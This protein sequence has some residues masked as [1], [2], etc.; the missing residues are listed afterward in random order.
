[1]ELIKVS[2]LTQ[3]TL[4]KVMPHKKKSWAA[5]FVIFTFL[6]ILVAG[7]GVFS[8]A[9]S[10]AYH[11]PEH[12]DQGHTGSTQIP[13][14]DTK[15]PGEVNRFSCSPV[16]PRTGN[17]FYVHQD[18]FIPGCGFSL[19]IARSYDSH[20]LY[21]GP[22]GH[23]WK[24]NSDVTLTE[25]SDE[26]G[27]YAAIRKSNGVRVVFSK[28]TDGSYNPPPGRHDTLR[29]NADDTFTWFESGCPTCGGPCYQFNASGCLTAILDANNNQ[30]SFSYD[31]T[32]KL[33]QVSDTSGR[34]LAITY[35]SN[36][37]ISAIQDPADRTFSYG[38]DSE[39]NLIQY[40]DPLGNTTTYTYDTNHRLTSIT[41]P[42]G[43]AMIAVTYDDKD[44][45]ITYSGYRGTWTYSYDPQ[46]NTTYK[47]DPEGNRWT[48]TYSDTGQLLTVKDPYNNTTTYD[49]DDNINLI[50]VKDARGFTTAFTYDDHGNM[51]TKTGPLGN[52]TTY[53]YDTNHNK[54]S[55]ITDPLGNTSKLE[56]DSS[57][58]I[59]K[60]IKD[61]GG[62]L[63]HETTF[64]YDSKGHVASFADPLNNTRTFTY[65]SYGN[66][67]QLT[68]AL[69]NTTTFTYDIA[70]N[71]LTETDPL[72]NTTTFSYD[73]LSRIIGKTDATG[74]T[75]TFA[76]NAGGKLSNITG[77]LGNTKSYTYDSY[78]RLAQI[79]DQLGNTTQYTYDSRGN[80]IG[81][82]DGNGNTSTYVYDAL[83]RLISET[84]TNGDTVS[85]AYDENGNI[86]S[87]TDP[88]GSTTTY[89]YDDLNRITQTTY[90][91]GTVESFSY[92]ALG[93]LTT[94]TD[95]NGNTISY[96]FD[97]LQRLF[98]IT[99]PDATEVNYSYDS[100]GNI[101]TASNPSV[102]YA[103]SYNAQNRVT[104]VNNSTLG[105]TISYSYLFG[106]LKS[107]MTNPESGV[108]AY[109]YNP[110]KGLISLTNPFGETTTYTRD[111]LSRVTRKDFSNST[112]AEFTYDAANRLTSLVNKTSGGSTIS[113][114]AYDYDNTYNRTSLT[115]LEGTHTYSYDGMY[116][117]LQANHPSS[118]N[119]VYTY[120]SVHN[121]LT[122]S[123]HNDWTYDSNNRLLSYGNMSFSY[124][125]N[126]NMVTKTDTVASQVTNYQYDYENRLKRIDYPD[127][128]Y[129]EYHY[130]PFGNRIKKDVNGIVTN[131]VYDFTKRLPDM[132]AEYDGSG[133]IIAS[134]TQGPDIDDV[135]SLRRDG[136]SWFYLK[137]GMGSVISLNDSVNTTGNTYQYDSF[138]NV[139]HETGSVHNPYG[140]TGRVLDSESG[141]LFYRARY[142]D[143][144]IG[145]FIHA[146]PIGFSG[147]INFYAYVSNNPIN[148]IDPWGLRGFWENL[149]AILEN[150]AKGNFDEAVNIRR[151][152][153]NAS[154]RAWDAF[155]ESG[156][157]AVAEGAPA[158]GG[159]IISVSNTF[160]EYYQGAK[161]EAQA[162]WETFIN[163]LPLGSGVSRANPLIREGVQVVPSIVTMG[164]RGAQAINNANPPGC[165]IEPVPAQPVE[166]ETYQPETETDSNDEDLDRHLYTYP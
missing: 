65:D 18:L 89:S 101:L 10:F 141:L 40:T 157:E 84:N 113:S 50:N 137:D 12:G 30:M 61:Y 15:P 86:V 166:P 142:Y 45:V 144:A 119:E 4:E 165:R 146:D 99:Y 115:T 160:R 29:K 95:R 106:G 8:P 19:N 97:N 109:T 138:G 124:D 136:N 38:Y 5:L 94:K 105:K 159:W 112:Y 121:R 2:K 143:P 37:K 25:T 77:P 35:G 14:R 28:N 118:S 134:Y 76:Y 42:N 82:T 6:F 149:S 7:T 111:K 26:S 47:D 122:S 127:G 64:T 110:R 78:N 135:I 39:G 140:Y 55:T 51:L 75:T 133:S 58:G 155:W 36:N 130:D 93:N 164:G 126:G 23:G 79:I 69:G 60:I 57:G 161:S 108:T 145:R 71:K 59:T 32:G 163:L 102:S 11:D 81:V 103:F 125:A 16:H 70:G 151:R 13:P 27:E 44:R 128:T 98:G 123:D 90:P 87:I 17:F 96:S 156:P 150:V 43:N 54:I 67:T 46:N 162:A 91:D 107:T 66:L 117:L 22:F 20:D 116:Q 114:F 147:G 100:N 92:N 152:M 24:F 73:D 3:P 53:T 62:A 83:N 131:F 85:Y 74:N 33:T 41:D 132:I 52:V 56:Y 63:E 49:W 129:S 88:K 148:K 68:D 139:I 72:G 31:G 153:G 120:D 21:D 9:P 34:E 1:M 104:Q 158:P 80:R 154:Q 48:M